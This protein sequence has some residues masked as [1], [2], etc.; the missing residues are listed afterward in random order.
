MSCV[1]FEALCRRFCQ[2]FFFWIEADERF[3]S[4]NFTAPVQALLLVREFGNHKGDE[5]T[6]RA[7]QN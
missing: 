1:W 6:N 2:F 5:V 4:G 3:Q 7:G